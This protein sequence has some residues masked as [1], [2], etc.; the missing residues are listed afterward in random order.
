[1][2]VQLPCFRFSYNDEMSEI[3]QFGVD[4]SHSGSQILGHDEYLS[5]AVIQVV[6]VVLGDRH[7]ADWYGDGTDFHGTKVAGEKFRAVREADHDSVFGLHTQ[8]EEGVAKTV[9][10]LCKLSIRDS[11]ALIVNGDFS[12][13]T[14]RQVP[15][16]KEGSEIK[17]LRHNRR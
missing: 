1:M 6:E 2:I 10:R 9:G 11:F 17:F 5:P 13:P 3:P 15:V 8:A 16:E 14:F 4:P 12:R 7:G